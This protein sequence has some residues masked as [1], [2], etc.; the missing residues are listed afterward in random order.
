MMS[1]AR[2]TD[3][4]S[5]KLSRVFGSLE[6][7]GDIETGSHVCPKT[8]GSGSGSVANQFDSSASPSRSLAPTIVNSQTKRI[9]RL[10]LNAPDITQSSL[11][12]HSYAL[13]E[14]GRTPAFPFLQSIREGHSLK[15]WGSFRYR[16]QMKSPVFD[17]RTRDFS[18]LY[19][20][21]TGKNKS[22]TNLIE[23]I[24]FSPR[25]SEVR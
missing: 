20:S 17:R 3:N 11:S 1:P 16:K 5:G 6:N 13:F 8:K 10:N 19:Y 25:K 24:S 21:Q 14:R 23:F 2:I 4:E 9:S 7:G 15:K 12:Q 22:A 18:E